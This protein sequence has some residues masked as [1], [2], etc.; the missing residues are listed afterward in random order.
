M[1]TN[2]HTGPEPGLAQLATSIIG[3]VQELF[4]QQL[5]LFK[6]EVEVNFR[7]AREATASLAVGLTLAF[8][9]VVLFCF[10]VVYFLS[11]VIPGLPLWGS[12]L[13]VAA[14]VGIPGAILLHNAREQFRSVSPLPRESAEALKENVE[15]TTKPR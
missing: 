2:L 13:I 12:F 1:S 6:H 9:G 4:R 8:L 11:W 15:W 5:D 7:K 10:A 3:D 14:A